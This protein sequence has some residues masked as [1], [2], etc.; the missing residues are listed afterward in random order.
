[1][2][3]KPA[4]IEQAFL[5]ILKEDSDRDEIRQRIG[6]FSSAYQ[7]ELGALALK[8]RLPAI[9]YSRLLKLGLEDILPEFNL[10]LKNQCLVNLEINARLE[11]ELKK[12]ISWLKKN[13]IPAIPLKGP[14]LAVFLY[15]SLA[16]RQASCDLDLLVQEERV[17]EAQKKLSEIGYNFFRDY[18]K[19]AFL[20]AFEREISL[21]RKIGPRRVAIDLHW[22]FKDRFISAHIASFWSNAR[23][24]NI[25]GQQVLFPVLEDLLLYLV[26]AAIYRFSFVEIKYLYD[27]HTLITK[28]GAGIAWDAV[29]DKARQSELN[30]ALYF[31]LDMCRDL[32]A[33]QISKELLESLRPPLLKE[34]VCRLWINRANILR[35]DYKIASSYGWRVFANSYLYSNGILRSM[36]KIFSIV[37]PSMEK[38]M[39]EYGRPL[40]EVS[41][42]L[43]LKRLLKPI[44]RF[45]L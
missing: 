23:D 17:D 9:F 29:A 14:I 45:E 16:F 1:M 3:R 21:Q 40:S 2:M 32:F 39:G 6:N 10:R 11:G 12:V 18:P 15:D 27:I 7:Q 30:T 36:N 4:E 37:F 31:V 33:T 20:R 8:S 44:M 34:T 41:Y 42:R 26:L 25:D 19:P 28:F 38:V 24:I 43:Y 5:D 13:D 22:G 35:R